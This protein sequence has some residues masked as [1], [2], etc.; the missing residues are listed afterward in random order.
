MTKKEEKEY[1]DKEW[2]EM[3]A[4]LQGFLETGSQD[5]LHDFRVQ[6]KKLRAFLMLADSIDDRPK[7]IRHFK[8][9]RKIF[10]K[11]GDIRNAHINLKLA[12][13]YKI[14]SD[15]FVLEQDQLMQQ[16]AD[17]FRLKGERYITKLKDAHKELKDEIKPV[18]DLLVNQYY[19]EHLQQVANSLNNI[20][21]DDSLHEC[22]KWIKVLIYNFK[23]AHT[24]LETAFN[25]TYLHHIQNAIGNW[26]DNVLAK[27]L[28]ISHGLSDETLMARIN[29]K[30]KQLEN[31]IKKLVKD[32]YAQA[33]TV[34]DLPVE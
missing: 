28:F 33:T 22:R 5:A 26:H 17:D 27:E 4:S 32:F 13:T 23:L 21:F 30:H 8:P 2:K 16:A 15:A 24:S 31:K 12:R 9:V 25:E 11:A 19:T 29:R 34:V 6:V 7:L 3:K 20:H 1:F 10:K 14:E 18:S